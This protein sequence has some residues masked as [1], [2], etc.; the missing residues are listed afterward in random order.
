M[1][2]KDIHIIDIEDNLYFLVFH[3]ILD[4]GFGTAVSLYINNYELSYL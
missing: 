4:K 1:L 2:R 3:K